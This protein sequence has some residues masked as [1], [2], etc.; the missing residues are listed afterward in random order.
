MR[1]ILFLLILSVS[2]GASKPTDSVGQAF[3]FA[4]LYRR[5]RRLLK[6]WSKVLHAKAK[7]GAKTKVVFSLSLKE[8]DHFEGPAASIYIDHGASADLDEC[9]HLNP[10]ELANIS[11]KIQVSE[12]MKESISEL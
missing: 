8:E 12:T 4:A 2:A 9:N 6:T 10:T 7:E 3:G 11:T 1:V 5:A